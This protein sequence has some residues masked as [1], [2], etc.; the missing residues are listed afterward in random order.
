MSEQEYPKKCWFCYR[1]IEK[2][3]EYA[4][5]DEFGH[6]ACHPCAKSM[7]AA[8]EREYAEARERQALAKEMQRRFTI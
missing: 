8:R 2:K 1:K 5:V 3:A 6:D 7:I 4:G